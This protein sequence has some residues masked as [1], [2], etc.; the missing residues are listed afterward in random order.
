[1]NKLSIVVPCYN[2]ENVIETFYNKLMEITE[3]ISDNYDYEVIFVDDGSKDETFS[4]MKN[5]REKNDKIKIISFSRNFGKEAGIHA[6]LSN[7][8]GELTVVM[9]ADLQH[10]PE[11]ILEML[12][13]IEEGYDTVATRRKNRKG[14]PVF[15]S[16]CARMFYKLINNFM[17]VKLEEGAQD[18]RMMKRNVVDAI[19]SLDEYNRFSKGIFNWVGFKCKYI[20]ID[21]VKRVAGKTK[22]SFS[23]LWKYAME[24]ITSFTTAPL[25]IAIFIGIFVFI[26]ST[27]F[28]FTIIV[29]TLIMGKDVPG[30]ASTI[31]S[32][33]FMGAIQLLC[34]GILSEYIS[35]MYMEIKNRPKYIIRDKI[36]NEK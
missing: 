22:W 14:E 13:Y 4:K 9:D 10:P 15:K 8:T 2:E 28:A 26:V 5:L 1:M 12:K 17:E 16:F 34:I 11:I 31:V 7:S 19:L 18:F 29:Q 35:K 24:G 6:G 20:E 21:N 36:D 23:S 25:K 27:I 3:K 33:L 30:Y 32:V